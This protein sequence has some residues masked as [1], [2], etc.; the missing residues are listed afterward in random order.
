MIR[1]PLVDGLQYANWSEG[2]FRQ[3]R[4]G[5]LDAVHVTLTYHETFRETVLNIE[6][7]NRW[8]EQFPDLIFQGRTADDVAQ[9]RATGRT[10][11][12]YGAADTFSA[13]CFCNAEEIVQFVKENSLR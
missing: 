10:A 6:R 12:Y 4:Q 5:G 3:M 13:L 7:W 8:F 9:A 2:I 11:I 1:A